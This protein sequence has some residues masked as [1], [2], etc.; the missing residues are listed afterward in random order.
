MKITKKLLKRIIKE[1]LEATMKEYRVV[2]KGQKWKTS[3]QSPEEKAAHAAQMARAATGK[4]TD[5][6]W[7]AARE[8]RRALRKQ[9][10][11]Q[12]AAAPAPTSGPAFEA[13]KSLNPR[14][15]TGVKLVGSVSKA[16]KAGKPYG[17]D[18]VNGNI[19]LVKNPTPEQK[20]TLAGVMAGLEAAP[21]PLQK[22]MGTPAP[23]KPSPEDVWSGRAPS[24]TQKKPGMMA[25]AGSAL[26]GLGKK[27]G[28]LFKEEELMEMI[29]EEYEEYLREQGK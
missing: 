17:A 11:A 26:K 7:K 21:D 22:K 6:E 5:E 25:K 24:P 19:Q 27:F 1:E 28:S 16:A 9:R 12:P 18:I 10:K 4:M 15:A 23:R 14:S 3:K 13:G 29:Q 20:Q 8:K 2:D